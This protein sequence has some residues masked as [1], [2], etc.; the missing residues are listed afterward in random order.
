MNV[1]NSGALRSVLFGTVLNSCQGMLSPREA[2][3][4]TPHV[5]ALPYRPACSSSAR[6]SRARAVSGGGIP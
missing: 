5:P 3:A 4:P 6:V 1:R 2:V